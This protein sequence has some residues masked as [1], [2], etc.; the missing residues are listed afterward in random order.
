VRTGLSTCSSSI[1][2]GTSSSSRNDRLT[3]FR[4]QVMEVT[5]ATF[6]TT[7]SYSHNLLTSLVLLLGTTPFLPNLTA[8][9]IPLGSTPSLTIVFIWSSK[10]QDV[11]CRRKGGAIS[12]RI[13][14]KA[15]TGYSTVVPAS[16]SPVVNLFKFASAVST[17]HRVHECKTPLCSSTQEQQLPAN[18]HVVSETTS[19][20]CRILRTPSQ[21]KGAINKGKYRME[22]GLYLIGL[23][24]HIGPLRISFNRSPLLVFQRSNWFEVSDSCILLRREG[25]V[26]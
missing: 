9:L 14:N 22:A 13:R 25:K 5:G 6:A 15:E 10:L 18:H 4:R 24:L 3:Y 21:R 1:T 16:T 11:R 17:L 19:Q 26:T 7:G 20:R 23:G 8:A 12:R 2:E